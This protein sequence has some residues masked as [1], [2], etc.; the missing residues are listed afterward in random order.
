MAAEPLGAAGVALPPEGS[1]QTQRVHWHPWRHLGNRHMQS[2]RVHQPGAAGPVAVE[3]E[4]T[5]PA[6]ATVMG[7]P[8]EAAQA[9][10]VVAGPPAA[11]AS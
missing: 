3:A 5:L 2:Q 8:L 10:E 4:L 1:L 7:T 9:A 11:S 6:A